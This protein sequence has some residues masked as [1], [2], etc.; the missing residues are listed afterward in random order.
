M[1]NVYRVIENDCRT[2]TGSNRRNAILECQCDSSTRIEKKDVDK[3]QF[4]N[5]PAG[6]EWRV[7]LVTEL[8]GIRD[9]SLMTVGWSN[10]DIKDALEYLCTT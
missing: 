2:I 9:G 10:N 3:L 8:I 1:K 6:E 4:H 5:V 7:Q